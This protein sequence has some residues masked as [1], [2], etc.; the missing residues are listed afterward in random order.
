MAKS[1]SRVL[2]TILT[3]TGVLIFF[4]PYLLE[5][6][7]SA[8][9]FQVGGAVMAVVCGLARCCFTEDECRR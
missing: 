3:Y 9:R 7:T 8:W 2:L 1:V 5:K 6:S 4:V